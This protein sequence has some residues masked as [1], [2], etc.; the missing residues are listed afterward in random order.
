MKLPVHPVKSPTR[1]RTPTRSGHHVSWKGRESNVDFSHNQR[2]TTQTSLHSRGKRGRGRG[3]RTREKNG[4]L[5]A[6]D[7]GTA[8]KFTRETVQYFFESSLTMTKSLLSWTVTAK[9][10]LPFR[11]AI[12]AV[13]RSGFKTISLP[14]PACCSL[15][16]SRS[17]RSHA[18]LPFPTRREGERCVTS[19]RAAAKETRPAASKF[20]S[21]N[22][23]SSSN[24]VNSRGTYCQKLTNQ[25][26]AAA[27]GHRNEK[28]G[29]FVAGV[30]GVPSSLPHSPLFFSRV[31]APLSPPRLR[32]LRRL[33]ADCLANSSARECPRVTCSVSFELICRVSKWWH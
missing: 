18:T 26:F 33:H 29:V 4:V 22:C 5:G 6:R 19:A 16:R 17:G 11:R 1:E 23:T 27:G 32:L 14:G 7:E 10:S 31:L 21:S 15:L 30:T 25:N 28:V 8:L 12:T 24:Y 13:S 3:A 9:T 2:C 20:K